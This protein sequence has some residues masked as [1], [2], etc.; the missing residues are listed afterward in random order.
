MIAGNAGILVSRVLYTKRGESK[1]FTIIDAGMNDLMRPTLDDAH[2]EIWP[3]AEPLPGAK[4]IVTDV[5]GPVC[6]TGDYFALAR[7]LPEL[8]DGDLVALMTAGAYGAVLASTYNSRLLVPE[9]MVS[10]DRYAVVRPRPSY[11]DM[12]EA[13]MIPGWIAVQW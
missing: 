3:V 1:H 2:H 13:E 7:T 11:E 12:L 5:V 6:E 10:G 4:Q 9:V 8:A